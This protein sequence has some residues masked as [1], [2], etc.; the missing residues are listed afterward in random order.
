MPG[1]SVTQRWQADDLDRGGCDADDG[2]PPAEPAAGETPEGDAGGRHQRRA[3][4]PGR[5]TTW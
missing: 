3:D 2:D 5:G 1:T 4:A